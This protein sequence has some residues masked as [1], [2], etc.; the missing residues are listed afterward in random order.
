MN[1]P[2]DI[3]LTDIQLHCHKHRKPNSV[4]R[5]IF[6]SVRN[7]NPGRFHGKKISVNENGEFE[8]FIPYSS[9]DR[10]RIRKARQE[11]AEIRIV[12]PI[13]GIPVRLGSDTIEYLSAKRKKSF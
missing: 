2:T 3:V 10:D 9:E 8:V 5:N 12:L 6:R 1:R 11:G 4:F 7:G 13:E